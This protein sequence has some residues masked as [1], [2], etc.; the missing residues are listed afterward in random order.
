MA[1]AL[2]D[3]EAEKQAAVARARDLEARIEM[4][5]EILKYLGDDD[6]KHV[7]RSNCHGCGL[8][9]ETAGRGAP[10]RKRFS[11]GRQQNARQRGR[12]GQVHCRRRDECRRSKPAPIGPTMRKGDPRLLRGLIRVER[13]LSGF[14]PLNQLFDAEQS[15]LVRK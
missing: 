3:A 1:D 13:P 15:G 5:V 8:R 2:D 12:R 14:R 7:L 4:V 10:L 9:Q 6:R 11:Y